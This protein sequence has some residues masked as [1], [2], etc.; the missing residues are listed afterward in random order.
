M[1]SDALKRETGC[2]RA[3]SLKRVGVR[4]QP[5]AQR[6]SRFSAKQGAAVA[7]A[8]S[9]LRRFVDCDFLA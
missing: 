1:S 9:T 8:T 7:A 5:M 6:I 2:R 4:R 3:K